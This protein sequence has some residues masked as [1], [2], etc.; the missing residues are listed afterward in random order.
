M[1]A[2]S[3]HRE[4]GN[5]GFNPNPKILPSDL[6]IAAGIEAA[7]M[8]RTQIQIAKELGC[9]VDTFQKLMS[10]NPDFAQR[11]TQARKTG[12]TILGESLLTIYE[13]NPLADHNE[14]RIR[15]ENLRWYLARVFA[16]IFG[17]KLTIV[18]EPPDIKQAL[19]DARSRV[20]RVVNPPELIEGPIDPWA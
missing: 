17:D 7:L 19:Q 10:N 16:P 12:G 3:S 8:G 2:G 15:S 5:M 4:R 1:F 11:F 20:A 14:I 13:D 6:N 9:S 18:N